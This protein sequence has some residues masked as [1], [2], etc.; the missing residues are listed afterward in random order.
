MSSNDEQKL[1]DIFQQMDHEVDDDKITKDEMI[2][3]LTNQLGFEEGD[4]RQIT[5][6]C[7]FSVCLF[8][9]DTK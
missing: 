8:V 7:F 4:A 5:E 1:R 9:N 6:V 2:K 3:T